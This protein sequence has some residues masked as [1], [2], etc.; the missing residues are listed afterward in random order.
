MGSQKRTI[1]C[2]WGW[3][4]TVTTT[5]SNIKGGTIT[6]KSLDWV[7]D[8]L[9]VIIDHP[10][11]ERLDNFFLGKLADVAISRHNIFFGLTVINHPNY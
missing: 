5:K 8:H 3:V 11:H 1:L 2:H 9:Q 10:Y 6:P 7:I 4:V